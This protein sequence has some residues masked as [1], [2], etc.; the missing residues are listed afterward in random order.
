MDKDLKK[1]KVTSDSGLFQSFNAASVGLAECGQP[2]SDKLVL[3]QHLGD[4]PEN[5]KLGLFQHR[6]HI[7][8][9]ER[10]SDVRA[11]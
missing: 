4:G 2:L 6:G 1:R 3:L 8:R 11:L 10:G 7:A 5:Y 9:K